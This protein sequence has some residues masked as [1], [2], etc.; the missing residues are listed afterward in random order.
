MERHLLV[1]YIILWVFVG[2]YLNTLFV[3]SSGINKYLQIKADIK[4][5][6]LKISK[7]ENKIKKLDK[8]IKKYMQNGFELE[9]FARED[10][11]MGEQEETVYLLND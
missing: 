4:L 2:I 11:L 5:E 3:G 9:R 8:N 10:L 6:S 7:L 1:R